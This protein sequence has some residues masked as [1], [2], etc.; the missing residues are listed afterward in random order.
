VDGSVPG[1]AG[2]RVLGAPAR[3]TVR[4]ALRRLRDHC[5]PQLAII[6]GGG[7]HEPA[8]AL[9]L[10]DRGA[11]LVA[12]ESGLV[13]GGPGL[14]K[15][16]NDALLFAGFL[17]PR[18]ACRPLEERRGEPDGGLSRSGLPAPPPLAPFARPAPLSGAAAR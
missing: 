6:A 1:D 9:D 13:F 7:I 15:R 8:H 12:V 10:L 18:G 4:D 5:G 16:I 17:G 3:T 11:N 14:P 2:W